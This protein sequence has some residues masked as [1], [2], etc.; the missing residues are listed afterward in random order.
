MS[1]TYE[2][3]RVTGDPGHGFP[4]Y[5]FV[6]SLRDNPHLGDPEAAAR[7]LMANLAVPR[8]NWIPWDDGPHLS[9]RTVTEG[10][11]ELV[12]DPFSKPVAP[13]DAGS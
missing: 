9:H 1:T 7:S 10:D 2:E 5:S 8:V 6:W 11:W 13:D 4:P 12:L 3:W